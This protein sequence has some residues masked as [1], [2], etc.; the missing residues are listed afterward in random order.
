[1]L[2]EEEVKATA[3]TTGDITLCINPILGGDHSIYHDSKDLYF[4]SK[5]VN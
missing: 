4:V 1:M 3:T 5:N 2:S